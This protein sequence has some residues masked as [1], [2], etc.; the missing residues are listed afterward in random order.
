MVYWLGAAMLYLVA[1]FLG[2]AAIVRYAPRNPASAMLRRRL[3]IFPLAPAIA[4]VAAM[5]V[6]LRRIVRLVAAARRLFEAL[7]GRR[8]YVRYRRGPYWVAP[9]RPPSSRRNGGNGFDTRR[10]EPVGQL[11]GSS[12]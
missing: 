5:C 3:A 8:Q 9:V 2:S 1:A 4:V 6:S 12:A 7:S 10:A 11:L